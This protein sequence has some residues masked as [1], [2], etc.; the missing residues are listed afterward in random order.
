[1]D[2]GKDQC[3]LIELEF[4]QGGATDY[5]LRRQLIDRNRA[6]KELLG[7]GERKGLQTHRVI[8]VSGLLEEIEVV[9]K[10]YILFTKFAFSSLLGF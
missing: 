10:I 1:L 2:A 5:G 6:L 3:R 4:C 8:P 9:Q 7:R